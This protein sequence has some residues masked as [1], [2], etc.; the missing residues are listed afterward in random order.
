MGSEQ[1]PVLITLVILATI[2]VL[3]YTLFLLNPANRGDPLPYVMVLSAELVLV[4]HSLMTMW[5][6]LA[7]GQNPRTFAVHQ[8]RAAMYGHTSGDPTR[9]PLILG[10]RRVVVDIL[11]T[12]YGEPLEVIE[13]TATAAKAMRGEHRT[14]I[15]DDGRSDEVRD[16]AARIGV[17]YVRRLSSNGAKA[18]NINHALTLA[19]GEFFAVFDADFVPKPDFIE[20]TLPF[21]VDPRL[22]FVQTPQSYGNEAHSVIAKGAAYMQTVF[23]RFVQP[24][25]NR[26]NAAF[27]VGTNVMFRRRAVLDVNGIYTDSKS[28]DVWTSLMM[29]ERGWKSIFIPEVLA[30]GDAPDN[31][32]AFSKQQLRWATGGFEILFSHPLLSRKSNLT[33]DQRLQYLT[34]ASFYLTGIAPLPLL[35]VPPLEIFFDLRPVSLSITMLEWALFYAGFYAMQ[36][37]LAWFTLGTYRWETLT[38]ATVSFP[39]YTKALFNVLRGKDV[40]WQATGTLK[41]SSPFN[42]MIPQ[43]LFFVFL[44]I[45]SGVAIWRDVG[46]G[47]LTLATMW[48]LLNTVIL[49]AFVVSAGLNLRPRLSRKAREAQDADDDDSELDLEL[50]HMLSAAGWLAEQGAL[51]SAGPA[52]ASADDAPAAVPAVVAS[53]GAASSAAEPATSLA[54]AGRR[55]SRATDPVAPPPAAGVDDAPVVADVAAD[56][57]VEVADVDAPVEA[58]VEAAAAD[59]PETPTPTADAEDD[60]GV[61]DAPEAEAGAEA[62]PASVEVQEGSAATAGDA[63]ADL[64]APIVDLPPDPPSTYGRRAGDVPHGAQGDDEPLPAGEAAPLYPPFG[65]PAPAYAQAAQPGQPYPYPPYGQ[66]P[67][68][69]PPGYGYPGFPAPGYG[70]PGYPQQPYPAQPAGGMPGYPEPAPP[71]PQPSYGQQGYPP[72]GYAPPGYPAPGYAPQP[73]GQPGYP[74][75]GYGTPPGYAPPG[76]PPAPPVADASPQAAWPAPPQPG[77]VPAPQPSTVVARPE[78][79]PAP[80]AS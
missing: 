22:A 64:E 74:P 42:F 76:Y 30:V 33:L 70:P 28:E 16:L 36:I 54:P 18:G 37:V 19:K 69:P 44:L 60:A 53:S 11:I 40:G 38:L 52:S 75:P 72:P 8:A 1:S 25:K 34:T 17:R 65:A 6:I 15:L 43:M 10:S 50:A 49:G 13:R 4:V 24:G 80:P 32:E 5:T 48:N 66:Q 2:G 35:L 55:P 23:Y 26:F 56:A 45:A 9:W 71:A 31:V 51:V 79:P 39:I 57:P 78:Q 68:F 58:A 77:T 61:A 47:F 21:F 73:Y 63:T 3:A 41:Q 20:H 67:G 62:A 12:V 7:G 29:H 14:W 46:N 27:C 59:E